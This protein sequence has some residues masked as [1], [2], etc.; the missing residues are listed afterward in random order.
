ML[1]PLLPYLIYLLF[2]LCSIQ[3]SFVEL[4]PAP[5]KLAGLWWLTVGKHLLGELGGLVLSKGSGDCIEEFQS[6]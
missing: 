1:S 6:E 2:L 5:L 4:L 3:Y